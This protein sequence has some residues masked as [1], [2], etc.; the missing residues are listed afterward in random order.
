MVATAQNFKKIKNGI[1]KAPTQAAH[2]AAQELTS[3][4]EARSCAL[5]ILHTKNLEGLNRAA[6][7]SHFVDPSQTLGGQ[8]P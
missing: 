8:V 7:Q 5:S 3:M 6:R 1:A 2:L 4:P